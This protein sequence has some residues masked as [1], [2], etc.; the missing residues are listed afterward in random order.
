MAADSDVESASE[1]GRQCVGG[2]ESPTCEAGGC[3]T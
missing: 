3:C 2:D 1:G